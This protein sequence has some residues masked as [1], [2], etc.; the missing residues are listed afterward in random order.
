MLK[1]QHADGRFVTN[2][3]DSSTHLHPHS[4]AMEGFIYGAYHLKEKKYLKA[5]Q[6]GVRWMR[7]AVSPSG[8]VSAIY[9]KRSFAHHERSDIVAQVL[10]LG[11]LLHGMGHTG[12]PFDAKTLQG[13]RDH[14]LMF[15][16][17]E[18]GP[19]KGGFLYGADTDGRLRIHLNAWA[20]M[21]AMQAICMYDLHCVQK[22][23]ADFEALV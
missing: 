8:S 6:K 17:V 14:L 15:Q 22:Q 21:F 5:V 3:R 11:S 7:Q 9:E 2:T 1:Q 19:Q 16:F 20:T 12:R 23:K 13:I 18:E 10:R 4:Y